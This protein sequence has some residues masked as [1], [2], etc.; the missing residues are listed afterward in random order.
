MKNDFDYLILGAGPA[1]LQLGYHLKENNRDY[2]ILERSDSA[3]AFF[4]DMPRHRFLLSINK[5]YTGTNDP[6]ANLRWDWNSLLSNDDEM[7]F[8]HYSKRYFPD[9]GDLYK[10]FSDYAVHFD[11]NIQFNTLVKKVSKKNE[12]FEVTDA[13]GKKYKGKRLIV[14]TGLFKSNDPG[15]PGFEYCDSY[16]EHS[17]NPQDYIDQ[18]VLVIGKGNSAVETASNLIETAA[19]IHVCSPDSLTLAW[20]SHYVGHL[21][22]VNNDFLDTYQLKA[23][24]AILDATIHKIERE[25]GKYQVHI[26]YSHAKG[27]KTIVP[28][29]KVIAC[30][31][32]KF[33]N[34]IF[35]ET[36]T[37][38]LAINDKF[39]EQTSEWESTNV[40]DMYVA[41]TLMHACDYRKTMSGFIHGFRHNIHALS[42]VFEQ[43]YH[44]IPWPSKVIDANPKSILSLIVNRI[45]TDPAMF[46]QPGFLGDLIIVSEPKNTAEYF[47]GLRLDNIMDSAF[48]ENDHYYTVSLEYGHFAGDPFSIERDPN[49]EK[50]GEADYLH[51]VIRRYNQGKLVTEHH[52]LD[53]LENAWYKEEYTE[54]ALAFFN[55]QLEMIKEAEVLAN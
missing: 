5:V 36:C 50:G 24:N 34:S 2:L 33:D 17:L 30:T 15:I 18:R 49:P 1:G 44:D 55:Q 25:N 27:Q 32:F 26:G 31:G 6:Q 43:K 14:A 48:K 53:D 22:A 21:R 20:Q 4:K 42:R 28:Y 41:G 16:E 19:T 38:N 46:L 23:Q 35:D 8:K 37:P 52:I 45:T 11:L 51:P 7:L 29:D 3:G 47:E 12:I 10:Y 40:P 13:D 9:A 39:P 54:P